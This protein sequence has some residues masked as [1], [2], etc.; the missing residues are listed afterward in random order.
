[1]ANSSLLKKVGI[2]MAVVVSL[3]LISVAGKNIIEYFG[4]LKVGKWYMD[5]ISMGPKQ[6]KC[7]E[8]NKAL[9]IIS[10]NIEKEKFMSLARGKYWERKGFEYIFETRCVE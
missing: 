4:T 5:K 3:G 10:G 1:M 6:N 9:F 2:E 7:I 8:I